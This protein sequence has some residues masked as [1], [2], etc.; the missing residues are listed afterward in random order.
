M[1]KQHELNFIRIELQNM[2]EMI[3]QG[4]IES[5]REQHDI[6]E[7]MNTLKA[8]R[9]FLET[10]EEGVFNDDPFELR[11][12]ECEDFDTDSDDIPF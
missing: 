7:Y 12:C 9:F 4:G 11:L 10:G 6:A 8:R 2:E 5:E 3:A 1:N